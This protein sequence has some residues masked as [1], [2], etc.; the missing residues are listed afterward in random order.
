M[1]TLQ[2]NGYKEGKNMY[3]DGLFVSTIYL[4]IKLHVNTVWPIVRN[5]KCTC[6]RMYI[7]LL[8]R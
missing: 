6:L 3:K 2:R 5:R 1:V 7:P 8:I 4:K